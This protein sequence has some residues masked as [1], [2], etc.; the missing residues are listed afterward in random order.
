V[1]AWEA[2]RSRR[3]VRVY[4][5][6]PI[7][8]GDLDRIL[9]APGAYSLAMASNYNAFPRPAAVMVMDGRPRLI[10]RHETCADLLT[11]EAL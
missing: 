8:A 6:R 7:P 3:N 1:E 4:A 2:I 5:D 9:A 11:T 10:R